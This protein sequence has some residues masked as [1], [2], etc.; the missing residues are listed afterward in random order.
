MTN[1]ILPVDPFPELHHDDAC[2]AIGVA[3]LDILADGSKYV[4][5]FPDG[6]GGFHVVGE[7]D[8]E[9]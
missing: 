2:I 6:N 7:E 1:D 3:V 4:K 5:V 8:N 9:S